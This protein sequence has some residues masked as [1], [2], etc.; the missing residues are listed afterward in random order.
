MARGMAAGGNLLGLDGG[1][2]DGM[3]GQPGTGTKARM[4]GRGRKE[5]EGLGVG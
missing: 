5:L 2:M 1:G 3:D 4:M